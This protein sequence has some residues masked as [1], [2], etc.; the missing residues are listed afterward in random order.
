MEKSKSTIRSIL[1]HH[2]HNP[3]EIIHWCAVGWLEN[4]DDVPCVAQV[5]TIVSVEGA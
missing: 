5:E 1:T 2:R 4:F 3:T